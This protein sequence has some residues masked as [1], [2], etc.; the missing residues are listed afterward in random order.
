MPHQPDDYYDKKTDTYYYQQDGNLYEYD[1]E[2]DDYPMV[3]LEELEDED[4]EL[5]KHLQ[6][7]LEECKKIDQSKESGN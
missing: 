7:V 5:H 6:T 2:D 4:P 1:E 3:D